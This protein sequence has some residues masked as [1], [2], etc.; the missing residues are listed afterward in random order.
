MVTLFYRLPRLTALATLLILLSGL[1]AL[2]TLGRQED[3][4]LV[5]RYGYILTIAPGADA[6][7]VEAVVTEPLERRLM[8]LPEV[9]EIKSSSQAGVSKISLDIREDLSE[10]EVDDAWTLIRQQVSL[11]E[12]DLPPEASSPFV[13]RAYVGA[14]SMLVALRWEGAGAPPLG[15]MA[16]LSQ[17]LEADFRNMPATEE[18]E[19]FGLPTEEVRVVADPEALR[20]AGLSMD[21]AARLIAAADAK[22]PAG[23]VRGQRSDIGLEIGGAFDTIARIRAVPLLQRDDGTSLKVGDVAEVIK[24]TQDPETTLALSNGRRA[25]LV[26]AY[27]QPNQRI[28]VWA[29]AARDMVA[30]FA[31]TTPADIEVEIVFDQSTYT[32]ARLNGL[33]GNLAASALIV[34]GVL[35]FVMGW[36]SAIVIGLALPLTVALVLT[37]FNFFA[38]PLHQMSVTGLVISLGLL[39]DNAIVVVDEFDQERRAGLGRSAAIEAALGKL[40]GP[41]FA[42]TLTT[43]LAFAPIALLPGGAGEFIGIIGLSVIFAVIGSFLIAMTIIPA[44]AAWLDRSRGVDLRAAFWRDGVKFGWLTDGYRW[45]VGLVLKYPPLGVAIGV[46]PVV[47]GFMLGGTL[48]TQFFPQTDRDQFQLEATLSPQATI[49]EAVALSDAATTYLLDYPGIEAVNLVIGEP[50]PRVYYN[51]FSTTEGVPGYMSGF[52]QMAPGISSRAIVSDIQDHLR[53]AFPQAQFLATPFEQGPPADAPIAFYIRGDNLSVLDRLGHEMRLVLSDTPGII[54]T[55]ALLEL[56]APTVTI[57]ADETA[58]ALSGSRFTD[59]ARDIRA[60]IEGVL[61]GSILEGVEEIPVR[62]MA[63]AERRSELADLQSK[64]IGLDRAGAPL[65]SLGEITLDPQTAVIV[66][67]NG[68]RVNEIYGFTV[69]YALPD[70]IFADFQARLDA[71]GVTLPPGYDVLISGQASNSADALAD[72]LSLAVPLIL[73]MTGAVALVFNSFRM[74]LLILAVGGMSM[75]LAFGGVWMFNLPLGFNAIVGALGLLGIAINGSIVVLS[76]LRT[77]PGCLED[78]VDAQQETVVAAT[79]HIVATTLTTMGGFV[80]IILTGDVF[81]MPL[82][83][84]IAGGITGS[85]LLALYFTPAM[86][87]LMTMKPVRRLIGIVQRRLARPGAG[88]VV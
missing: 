68:Q 87:R 32:A 20:A 42:S 51:A 17:S 69:P 21:M 58:S 22:V 8:E 52:V 46:V 13:R 10:S 34:F 23:V 54:F 88:S 85:A 63:S 73:I 74:A 18:T 81:W 82:A 53:T 25:I 3:P 84:A 59:V 86:F 64:R 43:A 55:R 31:R 15:V 9:A 26:G 48:P 80:P 5:E 56:G 24:G 1:F 79:R 37:L 33:A 60:E 39:I 40:F 57:R 2:L 77:T 67:L 29:Q 38:I 66:R 65:S 50:G 75:G 35:F 30:D 41:L 19:I 14:A 28:D 83:T 6:E 70:P 16:R 78:D 61:A 76:L 36:R 44:V 47:T 72:L 62:V 71:A 12:A 11:A 7:R 45:S 27:I 4:S 49:G